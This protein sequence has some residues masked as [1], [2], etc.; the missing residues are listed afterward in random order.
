MIV[1][2]NL[3]EFIKAAGPIFSQYGLGIDTG[4]TKTAMECSVVRIFYEALTASGSDWQWPEMEILLIR[5]FYKGEASPL[6]D[7][8]LLW[9]GNRLCGVSS[10]RRSSGL[11]WDPQFIESNRRPVLIL[12]PSTK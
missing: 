11:I 6:G 7:L 12:Y 1:T 3:Q 5:H 4:S 9:I 10:Q 2:P 8:L